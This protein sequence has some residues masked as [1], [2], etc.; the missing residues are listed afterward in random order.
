MAAGLL[1]GGPVWLFAYGA[2]TNWHPHK[3]VPIAAIMVAI[4]GVMW[5]YDELI[6]QK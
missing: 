6:D 2:E 4:A 5:L 3:F 1:I